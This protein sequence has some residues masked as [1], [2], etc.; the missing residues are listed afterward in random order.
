[1]SAPPE[2]LRP[3]RALIVGSLLA[4][5]LHAFDEMAVVTILP[6]ITAELG[7][8]S[9]YG[10]VFFGYLLVSLV[11]LVIGGG[12]AARSGPAPAFGLGL[13]AFA[14]GLALAAVA[15]TMELLIAGRAIQGLGGGIVSATV[16]VVINR[17]FSAEQRPRVMALNAS[18][19]VIPALIAPAA[20]GAITEFASWRWVFG[21][22]LPLA[23]VAAWLGI[24]S[25][26]ALGA[27]NVERGFREELID[28]VRLAVGLGA[29][30]SAL[31]RPLGALEGA[32]IIFGATLALPP[33]R[34]IMPSGLLRIEP[35]LAAA[36]ATKALLVFAFFGTEAFIPLALIEIQGASPGIAGL[37]LT[38][39]ALAW[40]TGAHLQARTAQRLSVAW[41]ARLGALAISISI[42]LLL[43]L[44]EPGTP[45]ALA[46]VAWSLSGLGMGMAYNTVTVSAMAHTP[47]GA[48]GSAST[49]LGI[50]DA[51]GISLA[52][53]LGGAV[54]A[55]ADR[56]GL[57]T[58]EPLWPI[59]LGGAAV[60]VL[61]AVACGRLAA[62]SVT[63]D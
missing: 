50:T 12:H 19:W 5:T 48:E 4:V 44:L 27:G 3:K 31:A 36:V 14:S 11:G 45:L 37:A 29:A 42:L 8:R 46:F 16:L 43:P 10:A 26:R 51:L 57:P 54:V 49:A 34:R 59:W 62:G 56:A 32:A 52:T 58:A 53:G 2:T 7:G 1:M 20:A 28:G 13:V 22:M 41:Q 6:V 15:P 35:G 23:A 61:A 9:L 40:T 60:A 38:G 33:L 24:P 17:G 47:D 39:A 21:G 18:A 25:M 55:A 63:T 30:L